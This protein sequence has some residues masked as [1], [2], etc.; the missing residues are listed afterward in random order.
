M[1]AIAAFGMRSS[2]DQNDPSSRAIDTLVVYI[3]VACA[4][5]V[6]AASGARPRA[7]STRT[8][9]APS[10]INVARSPSWSWTRRARIL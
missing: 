6:A 3:W 9:V 1:R 5:W 7:F 2:I 4:A 8:P 10:S